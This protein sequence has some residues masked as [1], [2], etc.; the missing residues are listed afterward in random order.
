M[1]NILLFLKRDLFPE[2]IFSPILHALLLS[3]GAATLIGTYRYLGRHDIPYRAILLG[4]LTT[5]A[6]IA[7]L[8]T[9]LHA[10]VLLYRLASAATGVFWRPTAGSWDFCKS[11]QGSGRTWPTG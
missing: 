6:G 7:L 9:Y 10:P 2:A 4:I 11:K 3:S 1:L 8:G 5:L